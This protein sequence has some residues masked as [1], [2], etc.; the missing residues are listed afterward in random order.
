MRRPPLLLLTVS[1]STFAQ[2]ARLEHFERNVRPVFAANCYACHSKSAA[3]PQ[4]GLSLDS[5]T[6][7]QR[8]GNSGALLQAGD[9]S[10]SLL[11]RALRHTDKSLKMPPGKPLPAES[12]AAIEQWIRDG[13]VLPPDTAPAAQKRPALWSL[14]KPQASPPPAVKNEAWVRNDIDRFILAT[15]EAKTLKPSAEAN[16]ETLIRRVTFDLTGLPPTASE[17]ERFLADR[18]SNAYE[19]LV[20]R[21]LDSPQYGERYARHW[22]DVARYSDSVNDSVNAGQRYP[23]S[24]TYRDWVI[25]AFNEDLPY[26]R[27]VLYQLAA[28]RVTG[29]DKRHLAALGYLSLGREFPK[30]YPE[31]VDDRIDAVA[32]GF[33]GLTVA[34]ARCHDHKYDP[35]SAKDYY[36]LYSVLSNIRT[37]SEFP[38]L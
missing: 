35:I 31:T 16:K 37:P 10:R 32:R 12:I 30:S 11:L 9:P 19:N 24:Y 38:L 4:G 13:A 34:C 27:F 5:S 8:G 22:L 3:T 21:L 7:I 28:D 14:K 26:D 17:V 6:A 15:L 20:N 25:R 2:D 29:V 23:W 1:L 33:L 36:S 18:S